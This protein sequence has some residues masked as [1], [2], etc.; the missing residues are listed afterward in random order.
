LPPEIIPDPKLTYF[1]VH[2]WV[3]GVTARRKVMPIMQQMLRKQ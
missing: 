3:E 1:D 2:D